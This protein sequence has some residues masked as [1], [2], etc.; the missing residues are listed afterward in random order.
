MTQ[1]AFKIAR[2]FG[3]PVEEIFAPDG[4]TYLQ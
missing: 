4:E 2:L 3:Q 1:P